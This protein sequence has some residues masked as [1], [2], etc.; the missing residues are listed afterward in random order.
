MGLTAEE[1]KIKLGLDD[2]VLDEGTRQAFAKL[3]KMGKEAHAAWYEHGE[4][5][6]RAY[7]KAI[8]EITSEFPLLGNAARIALS[9]IGGAMAVATTAAIYFKRE[10]H[11]INELLGKIG[12]SNAEPIGNVKSARR[13]T[14]RQDAADAERAREEDPGGDSITELMRL[15]ITPEQKQALLPEILRR[16]AASE[17]KNTAYNSSAGLAGRSASR[18]AANKAEENL[19]S[20]SKQLSEAEG[21]LPAAEEKEKKT[22]DM[23]RRVGFLGPGAVGAAGAAMEAVNPQAI[24]TAQ[25]LRAAIK[26]YKAAI[27]QESNTREDIKEK[28]DNEARAHEKEVHNLEKLDA[29]RT[30]LL[31]HIKDQNKLQAVYNQQM[32]YALKQQAEQK[33]ANFT[34]GLQEL[35]GYR[36]PYGAIAR[37]SL[38]ARDA[39]KRSL[40]FA[41]P[42]ELQNLRMGAS[43]AWNDL[44]GDIA[45]AK[46]PGDRNKAFRRYGERMD[47]M[48]TGHSTPEH[49]LEVIAEHI[50]ELNEK[51]K[52]EGLIIRGPEQ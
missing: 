40:G 21:Q 11:D 4:K 27:E 47:S 9:P 7:K 3:A 42:E 39:A 44:R 32:G 18:F 13:A 6:A 16:R 48:L 28:L 5:P 14:A 37:E 33:A 51:A 10:L 1:I 46:T 19:K 2:R 23:Q 34:P 15:A 24:E 41:S 12:K 52:G 50:K 8:H 43:A 49:H 20:L 29:A 35:A 45:G 38:L 31:N 30:E 17:R 36:G 22:L 26:N 25:S